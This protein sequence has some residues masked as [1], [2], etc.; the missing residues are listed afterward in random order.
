M[1]MP[2]IMKGRMYIIT[3]AVFSLIL[4]SGCASQPKTL[5]YWGDYQNNVYEYL[6]E[7]GGGDTA[8]QIESLEAG[9][10]KATSL[11]MALPPGYHAQLGLLYFSQGDI[12]RAIEQL[13]LEKTKYPES[14]TF[15]DGLLV[16]FRKSEGG[17]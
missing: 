11:N 13:T 1:K 9:V 3:A 7:P 2:M 17:A 5:Y 14:T 10:Q 16:K 12:D 6:N 15:I 4:L 8:K